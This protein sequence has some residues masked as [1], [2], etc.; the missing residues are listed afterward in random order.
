[1]NINLKDKNIIVTG[2]SSGIGKEIAI[3]LAQIGAQVIMIG[4]N[5]CKLDKIVAEFPNTQYYIYDFNNTAGIEDLANNIYKM[6]GKVSGIV[7]CAGI[8]DM[9]PLRLLKPENL[10]NVM[11]VNFLSYIELVRCFTRQGRYLS[12]MSIIGISSI[13]S[14]NGSK[15]KTAY[16]ASKAAMDSAN[17]CIAVELA[18]KDI[19]IN[20]IQPSWVETDMFYK[21]TEIHGE[22]DYLKDSLAKQQM[23]LISPRDVAN[24]AIYLLSPLSNK[25]TGEEIKIAG[26]R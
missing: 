20:S 9:R 15:S 7:Y 24:L 3:T 22:T 23:G 12:P 6:V 8:T 25:I 5:K 26:G 18:K 4:R 10:L 2:A 13:A 11:T 19:R 21:Y 16:S 14:I 17:R 1:M